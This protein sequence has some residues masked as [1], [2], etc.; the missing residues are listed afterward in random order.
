MNTRA[1]RL[2]IAGALVCTTPALQAC[3]QRAETDGTVV[4]DSAGITIVENLAPAWHEEDRWRLSQQPQTSIGVEEGAEAY[5]LFRVRSAVRTDDGRL[6]I[7]NSGTNE[8][9]F[10]DA[11]GHFLF[12]RGGEGEGPG[13]FKRMR[14]IW[15]LGDSLFLYDIG[16]ARMT[17]YATSGEFGRVFRVQPTPDGM[18]PLPRGVLSS[19][20]LLVQRSPPDRELEVGRYRPRSEYLRYGL[21]GEYVG[22]VGEFRGS[23]MYIGGQ[24]DR[25]FAGVP[26]FRRVSYV[27]PF[28]DRLYFGSGESYEIEIWGLDGNLRTLIRQPVPNPR[29]STAEAE[30]YRDSIRERL[31]EMT[32]Q[33]RSMYSRMPPPETKPA[34]GRL[35]VDADGRLWAA[36]YGAET[37]WTV[38]DAEGQMLGSL[39]MPAGGTVLEIGSDFVLGVWRNETDVESVRLYGLIK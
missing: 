21:D 27:I 8:L 38:F 34:Y 23:E 3:S 5:Q 1:S 17:V 10:F 26:P 15:R 25:K 30:Q 35:I 12:S 7:A 24:G 16:L 20:Y 2:A 11:T 18:T 29:V 28:G 13:E 37:Q 9:R 32:A 14:S 39:E 19:G 36:E 6:V 4:R 22:R 31:P 33:F